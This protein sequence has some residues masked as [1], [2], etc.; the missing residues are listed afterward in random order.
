MWRGGGPKVHEARL[1]SD[2]LGVDFCLS[3]YEKIGREQD[4][5]RIAN[6][7]MLLL[8][9]RRGIINFAVSP[10]RPMKYEAL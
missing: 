5:H 1:P 9:G 7:P 4:V 3:A 6:A 2:R 10:K 8:H